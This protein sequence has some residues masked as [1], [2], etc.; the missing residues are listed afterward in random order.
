MKTFIQER[1]D[2]QKYIIEQLQ[3]SNGY[4]VRNAKT[5]YD[6]RFAMDPSLLFRFLDE[7]QP[8]EMAAFRKMHKA[9]PNK[10]LIN[11]INKQIVQNGLVSVLKTGVEF[12]KGHK[13]NLM[14]SKPASK[15]NPKLNTLY[16]NNIFSVMEEVAIS[17]KERIDLVVFLNG[18][19][20]ISFELKSN[21]SGQSVDDAV[22]QYRTKRDP[23]NRLF[24]FK[25]GTLVNFAMDLNEVRMTTQLDKKETYFLPFNMGNLSLIHI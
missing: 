3:A 18:L 6:K 19:A 7:T 23:K 5:D 20:I 16:D 9:D 10:T 25:S 14:Y 11:F 13:I 1:N 24:L 15:M 2:F 4:L 12:G 8:D 17:D 22:E 21:A